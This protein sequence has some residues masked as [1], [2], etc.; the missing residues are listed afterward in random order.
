[1]PTLSLSRQSA[2][3]ILVVGICER[4]ERSFPPILFLPEDRRG[5]RVLAGYFLTGSHLIQEYVPVYDIE[6]G[7]NKAIWIL[8]ESYI[9]EDK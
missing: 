2:E 8:L 1:M 3:I 9:E 7:F 5:H 6:M 4:L